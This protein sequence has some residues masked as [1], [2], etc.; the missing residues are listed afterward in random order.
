MRK[1]KTPPTK[2]KGGDAHKSV[3]GGARKSVRY[4]PLAQKYARRLQIIADINQILGSN[5]QAGSA[6]Q[7]ALHHLLTNLAYPAAQIYRLSPTGSELWL[8]LEVGPGAK[9]VTPNK[10]IFSVAE[11]NP[12]SQAARQRESVNIPDICRGSTSSFEQNGTDTSIRSALAVP[13]Q[14]GP[15]LLGVLNLQS[16]KPD[17]FDEADVSFLTSLASLFAATIQT[18]QT[19]QQLQNDLQEIE[20]LYNLQRQ[21][22]LIKHAALEETKSLIGYQYDGQ[23]ITKTADISPAAQ[24][25][26]AKKQEM[27]DTLQDNEHKELIAPIRLYGETI[28][29][30]GIEDAADGKNWAEDDI[31]LL[32]EATSQIALAI[33]S[34]R[35][36]QQTQKRSQELSIL[37]EASRQLSE[38]VDLQ[39]IY[40][41]LTAQII[42]YLNADMTRVSLLNA[43]RTRFETAVQQSR[44]LADEIVLEA[45]RPRFEIIKDSASLRRILEHPEYI[46]EHLN[47]PHLNRKLRRQ[48]ETQAD[49]EIQTRAL[50]PL[51]VRNKLIGVLQVCH[52]RQHR[53][54]TQ[55]ELQLAQAIISQVTVAIENAQLFQQTEAALAETQKL[56]MVSRALVE[57]TSLEDTFNVVI[58][59]I[60]TYG[61]DR[62]SISL[63][64]VSPADAVESVT[65]VASWDRESDRILPVGSKISATMFSLVDAS[66]KPP[67]H[68]LISEDLRN[69]D[70]QDERM[71]DAFR[72][73][74][75]EGLGAITLFSTPMFLGTEYKGVLSISTRTPHHYT[76]QEVRVYQT[77]AD[78]TIIAIENHRLFEAI[79]RER[80]QAALLYTIGQTLSQ[81]ATI[82][83][84]KKTV[85]TCTAPIGA[86]HGE[87]YVTD[88]EAFL[89]MASTIPERQNL[90][91]A[92]AHNLMRLIFSNG[93]E[94]RALNTRQTVVRDSSQ[95]DWDIPGVPAPPGMRAMACA[96]FYSQRSNLQG[97]LTFFI[98]QEEGFTPDQIS[99][100]ESLAIQTASALENVW[101][102]QQTSTALR[103]T[104]VLYRAA[105]EFNKAQHPQELLDIL[106]KSLA[107]AETQTEVDIDYI[108]LTM[109]SALADN[110]VPERLDILAEWDKTTPIDEWAATFT[111]PLIPEN[112]SFITQTSANTHHVIY[113]DKLDENTQANINTYF[114]RV[115]SILAVPLAVGRNWLGVL[116]IGSRLEAFEFKPQLINRAT[117]LA[118]QVAVVIQNL[119]LVEE[120]QQNLYHSE[121]LSLLSQELLVAD[122][123]QA[124]YTLS[125]EAI[126]ATEPERGAAIFM[127]DEIEGSVEL[128]MVAIWDN[129]SLPDGVEGWPAIA[130]GARFS[131]DELG[132][133]PLLRT[134]QTVISDKIFEDDRFTES[135]RQLLM[136]MQINS[137][138]AVPIW[139]NREVNGFFLIGNYKKT[140]FSADA[141]RL[142]EDIARQTSVALENHRLLDEAQHRA[143]LLQTAAE[144]S[145]AATSFLDL[146]TLL[147]QTVDLIRDRFGYYHVSIFL[148]DEYRNYAVVEASTGEVG[149]KMLAM[150]HK[151]EVGGKSIVGTATGT[152]KS[153]I[154]LDVGEDAVW[155]NNPLLP[156]THSEMALPLI[157]RGQVIGALD[158][159]STKRGA[160][161]EG[162][163][164]IL[165]SM[166]N[167]LANAIEAARS[168]QESQKALGDVRKLHEYYLREQWGAFLKEQK[169]TTGYRLTKDGFVETP[170]DT[171]W[172]EIDQ[173][174]ETK[175]PMIISP[176]LAAT[177]TRPKASGSNK[178]NGTQDST[179]AATLIAPL[180]LQNEVVIGALDFEVPD[181]DK[182]LA[183]DTLRIIEAVA[184]QATQ[185]IEAARLFEQTQAAR[186]EAEALYKVGRALVTAE[187]EQE[188]Y[189]TVLDELLSTLGLKQGGILFF[190]EDR[191]FGKL[192]AL[193]EDGKPAEPGLRFPIVGNPSYERLIE[194]KQPLAIEDVVADPLVA[195]VRDINLE[196]G[197]ASLLL[198]PILLEDEV[199]GAMGAD[200]V[201]QKHVFTESEINLA[202]AM[203]DQL[204]IM[205]QNR[206]LLERTRR[207]AVQLQT[208]ADVGRVATSILDQEVMLGEAVELIRDRFGFYH[209]QVF[210]IDE[211]G[212]FAVLHKST[213]AIGQKLLALNHKVAV[214]SPNIIGQAAFQRRP[215]VVRHLG[216]NMQP[217]AA[218]LDVPE[219]HKQFLPDTQAELA[220]PLQVGDTLVGVLDV[221][222]TSPAA[223]NQEDIATMEILGAQLAIAT[224]NAR[225]FREQQETAERLKEIDKLKTQFLANMSHELRTPLNSIIGFSRVILKGIDGP[226]TDLQKADLTSIH[227]SGQHLLS[228]INNVL[229][230]SKIEAGKMEL[231]FEEV[232]VEP[233]IKGVMSTA[234]ALV[235]D[236]PVELLQE[237]PD[238]LAPVWAD[239]T[240]LRQI[241]LNLV[242]NACKFTDEGEITLRAFTDNEKLTVTV[243]DTGIGIPQEKLETVFEEFTQVDASTTRKVG[244]T[245]LG[246]PISRHFVEMHKGHI[247]VESTLGYG[248]TFS[249]SIPLSPTEEQ[250][251]EKIPENP[252]A[253]DDQDGAG[254]VIVAIDD[255]PNVIGLYR[256]FL[257]K[258]GY[259]VIGIQ[260]SKDVIPEIKEHNPLAILL[261]VLMPEKDGWGVLRELKENAFTKNI[262][263]VICSI[264]SD[265]NRGFSLG[266]ADYLTKPI[267]E[268]DLVSALKY[269]DQQGKDQIKVLVIDDEADDVLLIRR[270]LEAQPNYSILAASDG[271]EGLELVESQNPDLIILDL[272]MPEM[273]G[274]TVVEKLKNNEKTRAIPIIIVSAKELTA[275]E[276]QFLMGQVEVLLQKGLFSETELLEDV[277]QALKQIH[278][279]KELAL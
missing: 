170:A 264:V 153:R 118:G 140:T 64:D 150:H 166:A 183:E 81:A 9:P 70:G 90:S 126:A 58:E 104:E 69:P 82:D 246:L 132:L 124:I 2:N 50:F 262:P 168:F 22:D 155:F 222:S 265:K 40:Q 93:L 129:P 98:T 158:V 68:P 142:Y 218:N 107:P 100:M 57:S 43:A 33:E 114:G 238:N 49:K 207:G 60:K 235:K 51:V 162:D 119:Q 173:A 112:Y 197:I 92:A 23:A 27:V 110:G 189:H 251:E 198:V 266:A 15:T 205:L 127:Y 185:A 134:G 272:T 196:R 26:I 233:I 38:T 79:R 268:D 86:A 171:W 84:V 252:A 220:V 267:V 169:A 152:G 273:D 182:L 190:E 122:Q 102:L 172:P 212:R 192:F 123:A 111:I 260:S 16:D 66:A 229:D 54:Y 45:A 29:V 217:D 19:V 13:L 5:E 48:L 184:N 14:Y 34:S 269:V 99:L 213:G 175:Q 258:Q 74:M 109:I 133:E 195:T 94:A 161:T 96:P 193:F 215:L 199:V 103:E 254:K 148:I 116:F 151:L 91:P 141:V 236:K 46:I 181:K 72:I 244:G 24:L 108:A 247:W 35:L 8:Y 130:P 230:V 276:H 20:I 277:G 63:L 53:N 231:N 177:Q 131:T 147:T 180:S 18:T 164:T 71:D 156:D 117:T 30:I 31:R 191:K 101:L 253:H 139:L 201:G 37:F 271:K 225:A 106:V 80:D 121:I 255:D 256:R 228:L 200:A 135:L 243:S 41:I 176:P 204:S 136:L 270:I 239:P 149:R 120:T 278:Q 224:Q 75:Y 17:D 214:R 242:S 274:F 144:V 7:S 88:G 115:R 206:R 234:K 44:N 167:Q 259:E 62:V 56:Y 160:F 263:V 227:N 223:F 261:D 178:D 59:T 165:Q 55:N 128:E 28:G 232:E 221:H 237:V 194:T 138:V 32:E 202:R 257:E 143:T 1:S 248:S 67:F 125:L 203:A 65:I 145:Q 279:H 12:I 105:G 188:M 209:A 146:D 39:R 174:I 163:I 77:L 249:F 11:E 47:D 25:A 87:V 154:A 241:I 85:L 73:F 113:F 208:S 250:A 219:Q 42:N 240:R 159:Q 226:L 97:T 83:E 137:L 21:E 6:L 186:E 157:A 95:V 89:S 179:Q 3:R 4:K 61:I 245:G 10:D 187:N 216:T 275:K 78:Q 211:S 52:C 210:L 76:E 36:L